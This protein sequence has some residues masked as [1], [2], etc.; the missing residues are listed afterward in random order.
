MKETMCYLIQRSILSFNYTN[1]LKSVGLGLLVNN[2]FLSAKL[3]KCIVA[4]FPSI[5]YAN[6]KDFVACH[7]FF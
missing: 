6:S 7:F 2:A 3:S 4:I 5:V 1:T